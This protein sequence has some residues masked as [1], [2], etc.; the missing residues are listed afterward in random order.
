M[1]SETITYGLEK[2]ELKLNFWQ[3]VQHFGIVGFCFILPVT[4]TVMH[5]KDY[6]K[7]SFKPLTSGEI[8]FIIIPTVLGILLFYLQKSRLKFKEVHTN[9]NKSQLNNII[10]KVAEELEWHIHTSNSK[11]IVA[12]THP[13]FSSGSL[14]EQITILFDHNKVLV[15]SIC[16]PNKKSSL[17]SLGRNGQ[18]ETTLIE[19]IKNASL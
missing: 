12:R 16:D 15:N 6:F 4:F 2:R 10:E 11:A 5:L 1:T 7:N 14:G 13:G 17:I 19:N 8:W 18:N 9:L 3:K